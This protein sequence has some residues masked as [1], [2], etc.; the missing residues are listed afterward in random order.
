[1]GRQ[2]RHR[3]RPRP[4]LAQHRVCSPRPAATVPAMEDVLSSLGDG[5]IVIVNGAWS[6]AATALSPMTAAAIATVAG[7]VWLAR[8]EI[9]ELNRQGSKPDIG[10]H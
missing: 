9:D 10:M 8:L 6:V 3:R 1:M 7:L 2:P 4:G 5:L